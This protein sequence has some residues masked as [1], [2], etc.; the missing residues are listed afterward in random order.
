MKLGEGDVVV[1]MTVC[2]EGA[3][4]LTVTANGYGKRTAIEEYTKHA[5]GTKGMRAGMF[6]E[7]TGKLVNL[8]LVKEDVSTLK[9]SV[10]S[11]E[12][13]FNMLDGVRG[14]K[15]QPGNTLEYILESSKGVGSSKNLEISRIVERYQGSKNS[16]QRILH[17]F[18]IYKRAA[19]PETFATNL[20][21][22]DKKYVEA[23]I[24]KSKETLLHASASD[25]TMKLGTIN[26]PNFYKDLIY[27]TWADE[28]GSTL[29]IKQ[30]GFVTEA[31]KKAL[32]ENNTLKNG[33]VLDRFQTYITKFRN[34]ISNST[35]DFTKPDH[36]LNH[37]IRNQFAM[38]E[39]TRMATF[40]LVG[41]TPVDMAKGAA[42][43]R[44]AT[45]KWARIIGAIT[46]SVFAIAALAQLGF[47]KLS[48]PHNLKKQVN[49]DKN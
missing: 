44:F 14:N 25:H 8:K 5:R 3:D 37:N 9:N 17:T 7:K 1:D 15:V 34:L 27:S 10:T 19:N 2:I 43:R 40:N 21:G 38:D 13:L 18:D 4:V 24:N 48:N 30:K 49:D 35:I 45:Q 26:N 32:G 29:S 46:G 20:Y 47:G 12:E 28:A 11:K 33:N 42:S 39:K 36:I 41:Q 31:T 23:I 22:K 16:L 6:T